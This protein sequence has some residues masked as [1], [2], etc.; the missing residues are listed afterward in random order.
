MIP[1]TNLHIGRIVDQI[2]QNLIGLQRDIH[3]NAVTHKAMALAESPPLEKLQSFIDDSVASYQK[4]LQWFTDWSATLQKQQ[5]LSNQ[6]TK[7][8]WDLTDI[9]S[10]EQALQ[11]VITT[12]QQQ[13]V[14]DFAG[15]VAACDSLA[16]DCQSPDSLW[17]E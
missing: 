15:I 2:R 10:L 5:D 8:G 7:M 12:F 17:P 9:T 4:R 6:L 13:P 3:N 14:K 16:T 11:G 1:I